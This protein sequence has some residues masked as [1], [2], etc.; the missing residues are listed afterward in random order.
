MVQ[1]GVPYIAYLSDPRP[2]YSPIG[3]THNK[4][5]NRNRASALLEILDIYMSTTFFTAVSTSTISTVY[6]D[7]DQKKRNTVKAITNE[8]KEENKFTENIR[9]HVKESIENY[10]DAFID[11]NVQSDL[12]L[13]ELSS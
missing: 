13:A 7:I 5:T 4:E 6:F 9:E 3:K 8:S 12:Q 1:S 11:I 10:I 2:I